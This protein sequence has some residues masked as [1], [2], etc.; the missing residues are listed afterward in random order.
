MD[1]FLDS[2]VRNPDGSWTCYRE[3]R[4][5]GPVALI[6]VTPGST[7][8]PGTTFWGVDLAAWLEREMQKRERGSESDDEFA[9]R[10]KDSHVF[11][12]GRRGQHR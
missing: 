1:E 2:F 3:G 9:A 6:R 5:E 12:P 7:F 10:L 8:A 4:L 11:P